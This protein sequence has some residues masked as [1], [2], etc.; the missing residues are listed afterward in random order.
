MPS[1]FGENTLTMLKPNKLFLEQWAGSC[2]FTLLYKHCIS[3]SHVCFIILLRDEEFSNRKDQ[4]GVNWSYGAGSWA[5]LPHLLILKRVIL[6]YTL[7]HSDTCSW[8][9]LHVSKYL[10]QHVYLALF[11][12][13]KICI[14]SI[15]LH[16]KPT[17]LGFRTLIFHKC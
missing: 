16:W 5:R 7:F 4:P 10:Q 2:W 3:M 11:S 9:M 8:G 1:R 12:S 14:Y 17:H 6:K 13:L 15:S